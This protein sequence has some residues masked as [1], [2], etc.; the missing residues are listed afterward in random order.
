MFHHV[1][2]L[3]IVSAPLSLAGLGL[4]LWARGRRRIRVSL[5]PGSGGD[6]AQGLWLT[7]RNVAG[8]PERILGVRCEFTHPDGGDSLVAWRRDIRPFD[9]AP[10]RLQRLRAYPLEGERCAAGT[11]VR[12]VVSLAGGR[13]AQSRNLE[14]PQDDP[15]GYRAGPHPGPPETPMTRIVHRRFK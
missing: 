1:L 5:D 2:A 6:E 8:R 10:G 11:R 9:L 13:E 14:A 12:V 7:I 15:R 4:A 3:K